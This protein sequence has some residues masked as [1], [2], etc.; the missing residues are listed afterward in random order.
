[1]WAY[2]WAFSSVP[3]FPVTVFYV[4]TMLFDGCSF[5]VLSEVWRV[6]PTVLI[7]FLGIALAIAF[8][9]LFP[10]KCCNYILYIGEKYHGQFDIDCIKS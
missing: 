6:M 3:L 1:M 9:N 5:V 7:F 4:S 10:Y 2:L 8:G